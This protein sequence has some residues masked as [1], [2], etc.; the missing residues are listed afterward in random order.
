[1]KTFSALLLLLAP[2]TFAEPP[3]REIFPSGYTPVPCAAKFSACESFTDVSFESAAFA[4]LLRTLESKWSDAHRA[5]LTAMIQPYCVKRATCLA[6]PGRLWWFCN[7]VYAQE[8]RSACDAKF[9]GSTHDNQQCHTW[10]DVYA[11]GVDQHGKAQWEEAQKCMKASPPP[12]PALRKMEWWMLP[13]VIAP[14]YKGPIRLY[15]IDTETRV[16]V[17]AEI[18]FEGQNIFATDPPS[19]K[20]TTYYPFQW[21]RKLVRVP[22]GDG[23]TDVVPPA[24]TIAAPGYETVTTPVPTAVPKMIV[25][26]VPPAEKLR[27]GKN[28]ITVTAIDA[29]TGKPV[30]AQVYGGS[31]TIGFTNQPIEIT[32]EKRAKRPEIWVRSPFGAYSDVVV[33]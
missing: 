24:M 4:F 9:P 13:D 14:D 33:K 7:D 15:A 32:I 18:S 27:R 1:M 8:L 22:N 6:S 23:H 25:K 10:V 29:I 26:M 20:P 3:K 30:E 2:V 28:N 11:T 21:P 17:E 5:D 16:P 12:S 31:E 19:G